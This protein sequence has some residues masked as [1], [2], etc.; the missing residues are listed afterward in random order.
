MIKKLKVI[1]T[2]FTCEAHTKRSH[3]L[4]DTVKNNTYVYKIFRSTS[5]NVMEYLKCKP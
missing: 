2:L 4:I 1:I 3:K 5:I